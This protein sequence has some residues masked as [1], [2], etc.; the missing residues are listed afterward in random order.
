MKKLIIA[1]TLALVSGSTFASVWHDSSPQELE[2][3]FSQ[4]GFLTLTPV[5]H[6]LGTKLDTG[7]VLAEMNAVSTAQQVIGFQWKDPTPGKLV[8]TRFKDVT[9]NNTIEAQM[10]D[11]SNTLLVPSKDDN[12]WFVTTAATATDTSTTIHIT[13]VHEGVVQPGEYSAQMQVAQ[14]TP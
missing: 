11:V 10:E 3:Q 13:P 7:A 9:G 8:Q 5:P 6:Q 4:P 1:T 14:Y 12:N 2:V